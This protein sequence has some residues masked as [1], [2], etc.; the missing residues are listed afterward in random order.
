MSDFKL[1]AE[2]ATSGDTRG[3]IKVWENSS[4][5][6]LSEY[7]KVRDDEEG[8]E[9]YSGD[10]YLLYAIFYNGVKAA[11]AKA[12]QTVEALISNGIMLNQSDRDG[13]TPVGLLAMAG[14]T[15]LLEAAIRN[16][17]DV[18]AGGKTALACVFAARDLTDN[19][20]GVAD[21]LFNAGVS[22]NGQT[23]QEPA[24]FEAIA[25]NQREAIRY[26]VSKGAD[27]NKLY[28][29]PYKSRCGTAMHYS[30]I[31]AFADHTDLQTGRLLVELGGDPTIKNRE[32]FGAIDAFFVSDRESNEN[33]KNLID[34][35]SS[36][37]DWRRASWHLNTPPHSTFNP[38]RR[39]QARSAGEERVWSEIPGIRIAFRIGDRVRV[40]RRAGLY[41]NRVS[42]TLQESSGER[43]FGSDLTAMPGTTGTIVSWGN[44][45]PAGNHWKAVI[46]FDP[47]S[48]E[49]VDNFG[50]LISTGRC[51]GSLFPECLEIMEP[52][53]DL[54]T[55]PQVSAQPNKH[56]KRGTETGSPA[57]NWK[58]WA[59]LVV[60]L[61]VAFLV[62]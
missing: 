33:V 45:Y 28:E 60:A 9:W 3:A 38:N 6:I 37:D 8:D 51:R 39:R 46:E 55:L 43:E 35:Y 41:G 52:V 31:S 30:L 58:L 2:R 23:D 17:G 54:A 25:R 4:A 5:A 16:G 11:D 59:A 29:S 42:L 50:R 13:F 34:L 47:G 7:R 15:R 57:S 61:I 36:S 49:E 1:F 56:I 20:K 62:W 40:I 22:V 32:G 44:E 24:L 48:W 21:I 10:Y 27:I 26:L 18:N 14:N 19:W 53:D 12:V